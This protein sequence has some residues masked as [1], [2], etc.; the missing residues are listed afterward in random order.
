M[1]ILRGNPIGSKC[2]NQRLLKIIRILLEKHGH[3]NSIQIAQFIKNFKRNI[4]GSIFI[5]SQYSSCYPQ[6]RGYLLF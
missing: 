1:Q 3:I 4:I 5:F 2:T 6:I